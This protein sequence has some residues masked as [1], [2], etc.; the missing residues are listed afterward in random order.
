MRLLDVSG[1]FLLMQDL[2]LNSVEYSLGEW[3][4]PSRSCVRVRA[5]S[6]H[7]PGFGVSTVHG[8]R[9]GTRTHGPRK[10]TPQLE[11]CPFFSV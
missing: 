6:R 7:C 3:R 9:V 5:V 10:G 1:L 4:H 2:T 11:C 8:G